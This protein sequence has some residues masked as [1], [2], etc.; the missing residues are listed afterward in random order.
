MDMA[1]PNS[2]RLVH[3]SSVSACEVAAG[4][5]VAILS[6]SGCSCMYESASLHDELAVHHPALRRSPFSKHVN[7]ST[8]MLSALCVSEGYVCV[9]APAYAL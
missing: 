1:P 4:L 9:F 3:V 5:D 6:V 8:F 7:T 2:S